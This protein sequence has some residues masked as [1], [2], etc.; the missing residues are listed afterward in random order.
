V[1]RRER[2][3]ESVFTVADESLVQ[4]VLSHLVQGRVSIHA[5]TPLRASLEELFMAAAE[6]SAIQATSGRRSA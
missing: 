4:E 3:G 6:G 1:T 5:V 2:P